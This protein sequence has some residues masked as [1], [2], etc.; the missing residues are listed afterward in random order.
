MKKRLLVILMTLFVL[1]ISS[2]SF[3]KLEEGMST[4]EVQYVQ[5]M[6]IDA[7]Y[8][9]GGADGVFGSGTKSAV[10]R[11]QADHGLDSDG[12]V[13][14]QTLAALTRSDSSASNVVLQPGD[15]GSSVRDL[16]T[17]LTNNGYS[18]NG[19][20]GAYGGG[21][22]RAVSAFQS[23]MGLTATGTLDTRT[24]RALYALG[25][26]APASDTS[27]GQEIVMQATAYSA[28]DPGNS[29]ITA[30]GHALKK[31]LVSVDP[32][33]IPLG[34]KLYIEG[35]GYAVADDTGGDIVGNRIDLGMNSNSE[36]LD[37]GRRNVVVRILG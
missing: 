13:G 2:L 31:G 9:S 14:P 20:D 26:S 5:Y 17:R 29:G 11:F 23:A 8:L 7:G 25:N 36:A 21:T 10:K 35:Y 16:Q 30:G 12:V 6:L 37:F 32:S 3:A 1:S 34:T 4:P 15:S 24:E 27:S 18:T 22:A 28:A 33:V 19:I